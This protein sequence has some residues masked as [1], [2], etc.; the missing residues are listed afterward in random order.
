MDLED[1]IWHHFYIFH[2][3]GGKIS[4]NAIAFENVKYYLGEQK[5]KVY[6]KFLL[7]N[8]IYGITFGNF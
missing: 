1:N 5:R 4:L 7:L 8:L 2:N 3:S 6:G